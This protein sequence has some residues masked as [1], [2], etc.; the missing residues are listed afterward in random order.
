MFT[1]PCGLDSAKPGLGRD[2][3]FPVAGPGGAPQGPSRTLDPF[4][5]IHG[6]IGMRK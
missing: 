1:A 5:Y 3:P 4:N 2:A 6:C